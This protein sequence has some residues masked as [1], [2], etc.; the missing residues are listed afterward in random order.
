MDYKRLFFLTIAA[1]VI[2]FSGTSCASAYYT[3]YYKTEY[4]GNQFDKYVGMEKNQILRELGVPDRTMDDGNG[5]EILVYEK[6]TTTTTT[7]TVSQSSASAYQ[8]S[9]SYGSYNKAGVAATNGSTAGYLGAGSARSTSS[10]GYDAASKSQTNTSQNTTTN[11]TYVNFFV[12]DSNKCYDF[13][14]NYGD[15]Y[16]KVKVDECYN[17]TANWAWAIIIPLWPITIPVAII[18]QHTAKKNGWH[19]CGK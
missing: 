1:I 2:A 13:K 4:A 10:T 6:I 18:N 19:F 5:G 17:N 16:E 9:N 14:A 8:Q 3:V 11:K 15:K 12:N 7:K